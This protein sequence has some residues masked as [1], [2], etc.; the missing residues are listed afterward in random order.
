[1]GLPLMEPMFHVCIPTQTSFV[2]N[3]TTLSS[4][5]LAR[6]DLVKRDIHLGSL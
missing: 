3:W 1:M 6:E 5:T 2:K 4:L